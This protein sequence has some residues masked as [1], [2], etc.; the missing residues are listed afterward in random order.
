M[1]AAY[2]VTVAQLSDLREITVVCDNC[3]SRLILPTDRAPI[4]EQCSACNKVFE[5]TLRNALVAF[6]RFYREAS[7]SKSKIEIAIREPLSESFSLGSSG[8]P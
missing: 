7:N 2:R 5:D 4:P 1:T 6:A 3:Q 8:R